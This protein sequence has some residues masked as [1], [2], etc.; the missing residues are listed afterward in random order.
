MTAPVLCILAIG[1][2]RLRFWHTATEKI[3]RVREKATWEVVR[4]YRNGLQ[5]GGEPDSRRQK[6][7]ACRRAY[8]CPLAPPQPRIRTPHNVD[9]S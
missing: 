1:I 2:M 9:V 7:K 6:G 3:M 4:S 8:P 5:N